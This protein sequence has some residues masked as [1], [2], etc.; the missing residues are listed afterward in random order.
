LQCHNTPNGINEN[1][2]LPASALILKIRVRA[3][4]LLLLRRAS[5]YGS[6][7]FIF[8]M[9][10]SFRHSGIQREFILDGVISAMWSIAT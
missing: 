1:K 4:M 2:Q 5:S 9:C 6:N 7:Y 8:I 10:A 3:A